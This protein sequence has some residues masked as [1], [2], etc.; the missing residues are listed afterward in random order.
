MIE[1]YVLPLVLKISIRW[2][3]ITFTIRLIEVESVLKNPRVYVTKQFSA[4]Q[5]DQI[6]DITSNSYYACVGWLARF[7]IRLGVFARAHARSDRET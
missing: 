1:S 3:N 4:L 7:L 6:R 2:G 5:P